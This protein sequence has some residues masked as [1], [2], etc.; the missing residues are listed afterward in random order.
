MT[1]S[2][3]YNTRVTVQRPIEARG[4]TGEVIEGFTDV[5]TRWAEVRPS[6]GIE[7][8]TSGTERTSRNGYDVKLRYES[9]FS[10]LTAKWR[11]VT[12]GGRLLDIVSVPPRAANTR[13]LAMVCDER[14]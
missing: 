10:G 1:L 7:S 3:R 4:A 6:R 2:A 14:I 8:F 5:A 12:S 11:I 13:E 9:A